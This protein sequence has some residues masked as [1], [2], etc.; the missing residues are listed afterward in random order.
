MQM[1]DRKSKNLEWGGYPTP[2]GLYECQN[3][4]VARRGFCKSAKEKELG[5]SG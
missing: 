4:E 3:K 2:G 1:S 5:R